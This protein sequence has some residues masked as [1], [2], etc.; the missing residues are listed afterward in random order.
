MLLGV[1]QQIVLVDFDT[2]ARAR[3][4]IIQILGE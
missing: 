2:R 1:W 3:E 4:I